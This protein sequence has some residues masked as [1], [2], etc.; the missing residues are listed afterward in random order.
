MV[1]DYCKLTKIYC[2]GI[3]KK[4]AKHFLSLNDLASFSGSLTHQSLGMR[5]IMTLSCVNDN[6]SITQMKISIK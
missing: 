2:S 3:L 5:L 4:G 1:Q 6:Q